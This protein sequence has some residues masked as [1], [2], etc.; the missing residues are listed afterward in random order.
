MGSENLKGQGTVLQA[1]GRIRK[2]EGGRDKGGRNTA[3]GNEGD[4]TSSNNPVADRPSHLFEDPESF[5]NLRK[6]DQRGL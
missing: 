2:R 1:E 5:P 4:S 6:V 3:T